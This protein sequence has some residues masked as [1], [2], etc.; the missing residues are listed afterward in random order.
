MK[1]VTITHAGNLSGD[2][3]AYIR[4]EITEKYGADCT[5]YEET[6][7]ALV[8]G[9]LLNIDGKVFDVSLKTRLE[10]MREHIEK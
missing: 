1:T 10:Q 6:D 9:F 8:G 2:T 7:P 3:L 4:R 5:F